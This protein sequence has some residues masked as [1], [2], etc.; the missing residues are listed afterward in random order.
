MTDYGSPAHSR[1]LKGQIAEML[2]ILQ[3]MDDSPL[4]ARLEGVV[5]EQLKSQD[6][7]SAIA[8]R[9]SLLYYLVT[10]DRGRECV[11]ATRTART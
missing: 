8:D 2:A 9:V 4:K 6:E 1:R 11:Y 7:F 3:K 5:E 10:G